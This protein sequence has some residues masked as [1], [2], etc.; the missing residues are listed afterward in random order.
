[1]PAQ[2]P[3]IQSSPGVAPPTAAPKPL[4]DV[5]LEQVDVRPYLR[6]DPVHRKLA[7]RAVT[8]TLTVLGAAVW[9]SLAPLAL[10]IALV[11]DLVQR[12][13]LLWT[14]FYV[15][16][17]T[18]LFGHAWGLILLFCTWIS[19]GFGLA[20]VRYNR[21]ALWAELLW[22]RWNARVMAR[23]YGLTYDVEG[24]ECMKDGPT[25]LVM[26]HVSINDTILPI[27]L[28]GEHGIRLRIVLKHELLYAAIV[29]AIGHT[30]PTAFV[31][32]SSSH[33]E[34]ELATVR[35]IAGDLHPR[36][37]IMIFPEGTRFSN[38]R[39]A[40]LIERMKVKDPAV[41]AIAEELTHVMPLR[42]GGLFALMDAVP[43]ADIVF[44]AHTGYERT[45]R[46]ADFVAGGLYR[47]IV[48]VKFWRVAASSIP[49]EPAA[50]AAFFV[51]EWRKMNAWV[52]THQ[53]RPA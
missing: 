49:V 24:A 9:W 2:S 3:S 29:D 16:I 14:R 10:P 47:A 51:D 35:N 32:R 1:M 4:A 21:G 45:V 50:R 20:R 39:R 41:A 36:E 31:R 33:P 37:S 53:K 15:M 38:E 48:K 43:H 5:P 27:S 30:W 40:A 46:L 13:P 17:G 11:A 42:F 22:A 8:V 18:I 12:R 34:R 25:L 23:I 7:R 44:C 28:V 26:R 52:A 19:C 6:R